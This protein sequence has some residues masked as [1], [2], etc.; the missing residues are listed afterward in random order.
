MSTP[1]RA[2]TGAWHYEEAPLTDVDEGAESWI[3]RGANFVTV[4]SR[5]SAG[6]SLTRTDNPDE[7]MVVTYAAGVTI[8]A[9]GESLDVEPDSLAI[10]PPGASS[11]TFKEAGQVVRVFTSQAADLAERASNAAAY[12]DRPADVAPLDPWPQPV[13]GYK[14]R[15]YRLADYVREGTNMRVFR[16]TNMMLNVMT[17]RDVP[18]DTSKLTPHSHTDFEQGSLAVGGR[19]IHH[20]RY[21]WTP[22]LATWREDEA[23]EM[24]SPSVLVIPP[25]VIH[26]SRNVGPEPGLLIDVFAPPRVD[27]SLRDGLVRNADEYPMPASLGAA[28]DTA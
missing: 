1:A 5:G 7:Y 17:A 28:G 2:A 22:N 20:L 26:T 8:T 6:T 25:N 13:G 24:A 9:G 11:L 23:V 3:A 19:Y 16:S 21:P 27:F 4:I 18:R 12:S 15:A 14:L 10:V